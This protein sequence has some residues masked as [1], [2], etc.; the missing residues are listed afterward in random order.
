MKAF[1]ELI[2]DINAGIQCMARM[3]DMIS[4]GEMPKLESASEMSFT[5]IGHKCFAVSI[6]YNHKHINANKEMLIKAGWDYAR[7]T[8][9]TEN[10]FVLGEYYHKDDIEFIIYYRASMNGA[11]CKMR[12]IS[13]EVKTI[14]IM[15]VVCTQE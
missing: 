1:D 2:D 11:M 8:M 15:E 9:F 7:N 4:G 3:K 13:D 5:L 6:P 14:P 10:S 12:Q